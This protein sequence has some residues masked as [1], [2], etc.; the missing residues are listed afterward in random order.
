MQDYIYIYIYT[1][2]I[3]L[4]YFSPLYMTLIMK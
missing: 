4:F 3:Y 1:Y 2:F